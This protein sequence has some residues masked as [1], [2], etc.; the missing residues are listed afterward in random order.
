MP[1]D[2]PPTSTRSPSRGSS[3]CPT[4]RSRS[5]STSPT[6]LAGRFAFTPGQSLTLRRAST[7]RGAPLLLDL[8]GAGAARRGSACARSRAASFSG[9]LVHERRPGDV[10]DVQTAVRQLHPGP[11][12]APAP[13]LI[14]AGSGI[15]PMLSI[16]AIRARR[17]HDKP[18]HAALR[19][20]ANDSV[21][22]AEELADLKNR[23][24]PRLHL[25]HVLS[26]EPRDVELFSGRL[27]ASRCARLLAGDR[28][29]RP[30]STTGGCAAR[31]AMVDDAR[32]VLA[33]LGV[34][35]R[36]GPLRAVLRRRRL[37]PRSREPSRPRTGRRARSPSC[38]T[39]AAPPSR[40]RGTPDPRRR[41]ARPPRSAVRVQG[42]C[43]RHLPGPGDRRRGRDAPQLR[44]G[45]GA[46]STR[47]SCSPA[48]PC[49]VTDRVTVD[50]DA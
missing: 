50:Y 9:W 36:A 2:R 8:R 3:R 45:A 17:D 30:R 27:D 28:A 19:Q 21:M 13:V 4:T 29:R 1:Q 24:G 6:E 41:P 15:T 31:S 48:S 39:A 49:P 43:L 18:G 10:V 42:R 32:G 44:A 38:S 35:R 40:S 33:E 16:A 20:P 23:Y 25:V 47:A 22:F 34:P 26:R 5:P 46:S 11:A 37:R 14:A 7:E 12:T